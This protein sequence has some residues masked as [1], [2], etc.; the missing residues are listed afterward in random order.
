M[1]LQLRKTVLEEEVILVTSAKLALT[2]ST[3]RVSLRMVLLPHVHALPTVHLI[4]KLLLKLCYMP[5]F[6][7]IHLKVTYTISF[8]QIPEE[9]HVLK[10][11][12]K[13]ET[14]GLN[15]ITDMKMS[16]IICDK[17]YSSH[18]NKMF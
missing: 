8:Q 10:N 18:V 6:N 14:L 2:S 4:H 5:T 9:M 15:F 11:R 12:L 16:I 7:S 17:C 13:C 1:V 3:K